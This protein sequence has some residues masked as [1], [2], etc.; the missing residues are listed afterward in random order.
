MRF[1]AVAAMAAGV[2]VTAIVVLGV[3]VTARVASGQSV[4]TF[5]C[6][7]TTTGPCT[8][9]A[10]PKGS[11]SETVKF[12][13]AGYSLSVQTTEPPT[14]FVGAC[15]V[16]QITYDPQLPAMCFVPGGFFPNG[17]VD[18]NV[19]YNNGST[20]VTLPASKVARAYSTLAP[21][22]DS[23]ETLVTCFPHTPTGSCPQ[24]SFSVSNSCCD[25]GTQMI[26]LDGVNATGLVAITQ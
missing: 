20:S 16:P 4:G 17:P 14:G 6:D 21:S 7:P 24:P 2:V 15:L 9:G 11:T 25:M 19:V 10:C 3:G 26:S 8:P 13:A 23:Y 18:A 1:R 12:P 5:C 22:Y